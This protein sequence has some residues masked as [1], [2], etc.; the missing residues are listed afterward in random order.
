MNGSVA[1][2]D[3][4]AP[5]S[6]V[7]TPL[8]PLEDTF[9][10]FNAINWDNPTQAFNTADPSAYTPSSRSLSWDAGSTSHGLQEPSFETNMPPLQDESLFTENFDWS[11]MD[12]EFTSYNIQ[13]VTPATSVDT[14]SMGA[15]SRN[16]SISLEHPPSAELP[17]LSPG[18]QGNVMLYSPYSQN[19]CS[20][21]EGYED[22]VS[23][24]SKPS[25]DFALFDQPNHTLGHAAN[26]HMFQDLSNVGSSTW[27]GR[28]TELAHQLEVSDLMQVDEE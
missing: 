5:F 26:G 3:E 1:A 7:D 2:S 9:G 14:R 24:V 22:F 27:S 8:M 15:F 12:T 16:P 18:A 23:E 20:A 19:D 11:N 28:G 21:D 4:S 13:L 10:P 25:T 17:T 6:T